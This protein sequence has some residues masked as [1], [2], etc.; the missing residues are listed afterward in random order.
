M[1]LKTVFMPDTIPLQY[2]TN[3]GV[4]SLIGVMLLLVKAGKLRMLRAI[5]AF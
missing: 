2:S 4:I 5:S 3:N 1:E